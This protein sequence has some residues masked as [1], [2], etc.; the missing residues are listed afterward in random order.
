MAFP[1]SSPFLLTSMQQWSSPYWTKRWTLQI[2]EGRAM[3]LRKPWYLTPWNCFPRQHQPGLLM[4]RA[5]VRKQT[6]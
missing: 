4:L 2:E 6:A 1:T 5:C 3:R